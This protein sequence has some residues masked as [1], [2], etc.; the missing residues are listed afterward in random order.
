[1][2]W[3]PFPMFWTPVLAKFP[4]LSASFQKTK[5][6]FAL[7]NFT[8]VKTVHRCI[9]IIYI[10][11]FGHFLQNFNAWPNKCMIANN[12]LTKQ[13]APKMTRRKGNWTT[14]GIYSKISP[15]ER[16]LKISPC[17]FATE[18]CKHTVS[19]PDTSNKNCGSHGHL[20]IE[21]FKLGPIP[22][23]IVSKTTPYYNSLV[24]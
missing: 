6:D 8:V 18:I 15:N 5:F 17:Q 9:E 2:F 22:L 13:L 21:S 4:T 23:E 7:Q 10:K 14:S 19:M 20:Q 3:T 1:M 24:C 12:C 16:N 11:P